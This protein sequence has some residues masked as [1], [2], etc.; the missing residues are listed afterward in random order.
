[1]PTLLMLET[2]CLLKTTEKINKKGLY[3]DDITDKTTSQ[4]TEKI[5]NRCF[6]QK[7]NSELVSTTSFKPEYVNKKITYAEYM[8][9]YNSIDKINSKSTFRYNEYTVIR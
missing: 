3:S 2:I 4:M 7:V 5:V 6:S 8:R 1:M 9:Q